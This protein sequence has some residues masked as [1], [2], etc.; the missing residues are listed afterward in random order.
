MVASLVSMSVDASIDRLRNAVR[1]ASRITILTGAGVSAA[2]GIPTFRGAGGLRKSFRA[3]DLATS[4][5]FAH[6]PRQVWKWYDWR[7]QL[8][9]AAKPNAGHEAI[10]TLTSAAG[11]DTRHAERRR[12]AR[13]RTNAG[14]FLSPVVPVVPVAP[15]IYFPGA[16]SRRR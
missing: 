8:I 16:N 2:S 14:R 6:D 1:R 13:A 12:T 7:R 15:E 9:A 10:A 5:A 11:H 4:R 3:E